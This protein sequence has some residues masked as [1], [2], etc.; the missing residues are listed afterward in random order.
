MGNKPAKLS[1]EEEL[2][3]DPER[4]AQIERQ[5]KALLH[6]G[7]RFDSAIEMFHHNC[8]LYE[9]EKSRR[10]MTY[11]DKCDRY[12]QWLSRVDIDDYEYLED[13]SKHMKK[14][15]YE[16]D[17]VVMQEMKEAFPNDYGTQIMRMI[18]EKRP[19]LKKVLLP[20]ERTD[21]SSGSSDDGF[22]MGL[23]VSSMVSNFY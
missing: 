14:E 21:S 22:T 5:Q 16:A 20:S 15:H 13:Y 8:F 7:S 12:E 4:K 9:N 2:K 23:I 19:K 11:C 10:A 1:I 18:D 6:L 17:Q 3:E